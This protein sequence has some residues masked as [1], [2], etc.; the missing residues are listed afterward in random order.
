MEIHKILGGKVS[1]FRR[2]D[3]KKWQCAASIKGRQYRQSSKQESLA[4]A[5]DVAEDWYMELLNMDRFGELNAGKT[6]REAAKIF[7]SE[8]ELITIGR[9][10]PKWVE[11]HKARL[12]LHLLPFLGAKGVKAIT[13]GVGQNYRAHRMTKPEDWPEEGAEGYKPW[14]PP[15]QNT[16][17]NEVVTLSM[18]LKTAQRHGWLDHVPDL[19]DPYRRQSKV[20]HRPWFTPKEYK[21]FYEA[22]RHNAAYP[23][24]VRFKWQAEQLHDY[25]L[26]MAN[27]GLRPDEVKRLE[28]RDVEI[29]D[30]EHTGE[31]ILE[32]EVRG[33]R[34][35]GFCKSMPGAVR[36]FKRMLKRNNP[37]QTDR[38]F[39]TD[40]KKMLNGILLKLDL[41]FDRNGKARTAYSLRHS[42]ICFR[43]LEGA[44]I[45]QVAKN[46]RTSVEMIEKHYAA[47]L[48]DMIDT[49]LVNV[50]RVRGVKVFDV[51]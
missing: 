43:L 16:L 18:V 25:V 31:T 15:A 19:S 17:H 47:H 10:S 37:E 51:D 41:K 40:F 45:Y 7:E 46:C 4:A 21:R 8:Y 26:I 44:D 6:F 32:I 14:T 5:K 38:L 30:D 29:V 20:E 34:G 39:T 3:S 28:Y 1:V 33:K 36:P 9:R 12:R 11:G 22:T 24:V 35:V 49:R 13:S 48:K 2:E 23:K 50:R 42:Y 27:T